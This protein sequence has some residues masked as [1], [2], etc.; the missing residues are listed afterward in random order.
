VFKKKGRENTK[1]R[2]AFYPLPVPAP[3]RY[4]AGN[5]STAVTLKISEM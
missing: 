3:E 2:R 5:G 1:N 4:P